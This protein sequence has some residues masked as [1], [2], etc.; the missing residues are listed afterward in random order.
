MSFFCYN[1]KM[2]EISPE[3]LAENIHVYLQEGMDLEE[4]RE[5]AYSEGISAET[6]E[7]AMLFL[8]KSRIYEKVRIKKKFALNVTGGVIG[9]II[10]IVLSFTWF[11]YQEQLTKYF[12][13][14][15]VKIETSDDS[16]LPANTDNFSEIDKIK[17]E[18]FAEERYDMSDKNKTESV[19][20]IDKT[21]IILKDF[22]IRIRDVDDVSK[23]EWLSILESIK[24]LP[25]LTI[26]NHELYLFELG[27]KGGWTGFWIYKNKMLLV[28]PFS[29]NL[30]DF[31]MKNE[32]KSILINYK[33]DL[34]TNDFFF[35]NQFE[36]F[37]TIDTKK[38]EKIKA[39]R[40]DLKPIFEKLM[41]IPTGGY[42]VDSISVRKNDR[43]KQIEG[44]SINFER[45]TDQLKTRVDIYLIEFT[46]SVKKMNSEKLLEEMDKSTFKRKIRRNTVLDSKG[47]MMWPSGDYVL[48][49]SNESQ[50]LV[51]EFLKRYK[52]D[53]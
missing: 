30:S 1:E 9:A 3:K 24:D 29:G 2:S 51:E 45:Y 27:K 48:E 11:V 23:S 16:A 4:I 36:V 43:T 21:Q 37:D 14:E 40:S 5:S 28:T 47:T 10:M 34:L 12:A 19:A 53:L 18:A 52:S 41:A 46:A 6:F 44:Y 49:I 26:N 35:I 38:M 50:A 32:M 31:F 25:T 17:K 33:S 13:K 22:E 20:K 8:R 42:F 39:L 7:S 15:D